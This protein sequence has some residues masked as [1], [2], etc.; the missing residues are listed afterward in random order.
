MT[1][2]DLTPNLSASEKAVNSFEYGYECAN[3]LLDNNSELDAIIASVDVQG[4]GA[5]RALSER[6]FRI[7]EQ[8]RVISL[9]G[10][11]VGAKA[12]KMLI[13]EIEAPSGQKPGVQHLSFSASLV[14][15]EST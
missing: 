3:Q 7:P 8:V 1:E 13:E 14:E 11:E 6:H 5:I 15:R 9:T 10:H 12:A 4:L 2:L